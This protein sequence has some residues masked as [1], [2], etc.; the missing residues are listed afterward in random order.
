MPLVAAVAAF[1][2]FGLVMSAITIGVIILAIGAAIFGVCY[3]IYW[4]YKKQKEEEQRRAA[5]EALEQERQAFARITRQETLRLYDEASR[6]YPSQ[7]AFFGLV[8]DAFTALKPELPPLP[9]ETT[10]QLGAIAVEIYRRELPPR[11]PVIP[12]F[13][14]AGEEQ[15]YQAAIRPLVAQAQ[16]FD[17]QLIAQ[18]VA[19]SFL[20]YLEQ[21]P[22][23]TKGQFTVSVAQLV[24]L[25]ATTWGMIQP[26]RDPQLFERG[27]CRSIWNTF[28]ENAVRAGGGNAPVYPQEFKSDLPADK[29]ADLYLKDT[30][31][32]PLLKIRIPWGFT[33]EERFQHQWVLGSTGS[34]KTTYLSNLIKADLERVAQGEC[35]IVLLDSQLALYQLAKCKYFAPGQPLHGKLVLIEPN[36]HHP[37]ALNP[38]QIGRAR[39]AADDERQINATVDLLTYAFGSIFEADLSTLQS[40]A[41]R[42]IIRLMLEI[43]GANI[44]TLTD[45]LTSKNYLKPEYQQCIA[46]LRGPA[47]SYFENR[48]EH[49]RPDTKSGILDRLY[50][51][52]EHSAIDGMFCAPDCKLDLFTEMQNGKV[53]IVNADKDYLTQDRTEMFGRFFIAMLLQAAQQRAP[54]RDDQKL[55][56]F[57][58]IDEAH[59][60]IRKDP[61]V[62]VLVDQARKQK[63]GMCFAHHRESQIDDKNV[64]SALQ[65]THIRTRCIEPRTASVAVGPIER[66]RTYLVP[67]ED[68]SF[69]R[70]PHMTPEHW[71]RV[72]RDMRARYCI[73]PQIA[74]HPSPVTQ[75]DATSDF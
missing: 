52:R 72:Q 29:I 57:C 6:P 45:F 54:L 53:I 67:I 39:Y 37:L 61:R 21:L 19:K 47:K 13:A 70:E 56:C 65:H 43:P 48:F 31:F 60:Y 17:H 51:L 23:Q 9:E 49:L 44:E 40:G 25:P 10:S 50:M 68:V 30:P 71:R 7:E 75:S 5:A 11:P 36:A 26:F 28:H 20:A 1:I 73:P 32:Q 12:E 2:V 14:N 16:A 41:A 22:R 18:A 33:D 3:L 38:F 55:P 27:L 8:V 62:P 59:D 46:K 64:L 35:S 24:N 58:Y 66:T 15:A 63:V 69:A 74:A 4:I 42:Y 34:G